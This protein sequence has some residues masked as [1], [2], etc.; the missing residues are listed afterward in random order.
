MNEVKWLEAPEDHDYPAARAYL[1]LLFRD[2]YILDRRIQEL[3][4]ASVTEHRA[5]DVLRASG[6]KLADKDDPRVRSNL[7]KIEDGKPLSPVL[8]VGGFPALTI[9]DGYHRICAAVHYD[10]FSTVKGKLI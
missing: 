2:D 10:P 5:N 6:L 3:Q 8:L 4:D 1:R 7:K 9:A